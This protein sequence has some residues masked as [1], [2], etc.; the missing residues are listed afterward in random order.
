[1][2]SD[3]GCVHVIMHSSVFY[4]FQVLNFR[5]GRKEGIFCSFIL[6]L[7]ALS[8]PVP[9]LCLHLRS[10]RAAV[11][12]PSLEMFQARLEQP[13]LGEGPAHDRGLQLDL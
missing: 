11:E 2:F 5:K 13:A 1:M 3:H 10:P 12:G 7:K 9:T 4:I 8:S 6:L